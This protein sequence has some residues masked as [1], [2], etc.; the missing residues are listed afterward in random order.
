MHYRGEVCVGGGVYFPNDVAQV[1]GC[2]R[3]LTR[4][5]GGYN[6]TIILNANWNPMGSRQLAWTHVNHAHTFILYIYFIVFL[7]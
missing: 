1:I 7:L 2:V 4:Q 3:Y 5:V 6:Y